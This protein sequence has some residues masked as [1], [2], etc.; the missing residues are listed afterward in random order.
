MATK[1]A[2]DAKGTTKIVPKRKPVFVK[3]DQLT[4][5]TSGHTLTVKVVESN[6][7]K[8]AIRKVGRSA[9]S[10]MQPVRP[11]RIVESLIGDETGCILFTA[12]NEQGMKVISQVKLG[13]VAI[14]QR[15]LMSYE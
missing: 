3:V 4:P 11:S 12:R 13:S 15:C 6:P 5:G 10:M 8:S 7:V 2:T 1:V 14:F 9:G